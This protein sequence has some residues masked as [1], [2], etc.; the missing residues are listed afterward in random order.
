MPQKIRFQL[1]GRPPVQAFQY[2]TAMRALVLRWLHAADPQLSQEIHDANQPKP[3]TVSPLWR[4]EGTERGCWFEVAV[5]ADELAPTLWE[6]ILV[7]PDTIRLGTQTYAIRSV[8][9]G[10]AARW[11]DLAVVPVAPVDEFE[12][13]MLSPTAHHLPGELRKSVVLPDPENYFGS[14]LGRWNSC[15][16]WKFPP[17]IR[18]VIARQVAVTYCEGR[19]HAVRLDQR[20]TFIG[21]QG[22]VRFSLLKPQQAPEGT[23]NALL[24]L[25]RFA[26]YRG[27][28]VDTMRGMGQTVFLEPGR[29][30]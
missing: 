8:E 4:N 2:A 20:R 29:T 13:A 27:T 22:R 17:E 11:E 7:S 10:D 16:E 23:A 1:E 26:N 5:L 30:G 18:D 15:C 12:M 21:F 3:L 6:G 19:T 24:T 25:A 28:G 9:K 14:W